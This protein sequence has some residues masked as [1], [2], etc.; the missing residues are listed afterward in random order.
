MINIYA[1]LFILSLHYRS[2]PSG[3]TIHKKQQKLTE[4]Y[5]NFGDSKNTM[6]IVKSNVMT[7]K[8]IMCLDYPDLPHTM[9]FDLEYGVFDDAKTEVK[10]ASG[11]T[12][13]N[14][15]LKSA[16]M[17]MQALLNDEGTKMWLWG[18]AN[19]MEI[20]QHISQE[21]LEAMRE[22]RDDYLAPR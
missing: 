8:N 3:I 21:R 4:G 18:W 5:W 1:D 12:K 10:E 6:C 19:K 17:N 22:D 16:M 20:W 9:K 13:N 14:V 11:K 2:F 7:V 15:Y